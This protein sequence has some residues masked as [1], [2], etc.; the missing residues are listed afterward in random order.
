MTATVLSTYKYKLYY[1]GFW[2]LWTMVHIWVLQECGYTTM[3]ALTDSIISNTLLGGTGLLIIIVLSYYLPRKDQLTSL[4]CMCV[5]FTIAWV[6]LARLA[7]SQ[8]ADEKVYNY[9]NQTIHLRGAIAFL[10]LG[11]VVL[12]NV[13]W[14]SLEEQKEQERRKNE[15]DQIARD[16]ELFKLRQQ[17][18]PHFLF[19]SLN[20]ISALVV[21]QP[22][23][24]RKMIQQLSDYLRNTL[25][26]EEHKWVT[27]AEELEY[28]QLYLDIEKVRFGHRLSTSINSNEHSLNLMLPALLLQPVVEN[29]I[30]FGLYDTTDDITISINAEIL[31]RLLV[32]T[33]KNPF[34]PQVSQPRTGTGFGLSS[35][36]RRLYLLFARNDLLETATRQNIFITR[37]KIPQQ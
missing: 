22:A 32:I 17:L 4:L 28:L 26:K 5:L 13:L 25:K 8:L 12:L 31:E 19:N 16:A 21:A 7:M 18:Q 11:C 3:E 6:A 15:S 1:A 14:H 35:V 30:K 36:Q 10:I 37:I 20:S 27:L 2:V 34:D 24:A 23:Q 9:F 29:A 33:V